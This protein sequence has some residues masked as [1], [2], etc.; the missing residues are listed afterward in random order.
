MWTDSLK[1]IFQ[2]MIFS[3]YFRCY[4]LVNTKNFLI[5]DVLTSDSEENP[6]RTHSGPEKSP[7]QK[8]REIKYLC[9]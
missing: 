8:N 4:F 6:G 9:M 7:D 3:K 5:S 1:N 2:N